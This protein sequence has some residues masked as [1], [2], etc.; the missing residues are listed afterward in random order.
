MPFFG[1]PVPGFPAVYGKRPNKHLSL[2]S[3]SNPDDD[4]YPE[5]PL[6]A[7]RFEVP[8]SLETTASYDS[9]SSGGSSPMLTPSVSLKLTEEEE[10]SNS[11]AVTKRSPNFR[12]CHH[13][14]N[15]CVFD[16]V[17]Y[18]DQV[19]CS[20]EC[21]WS[22]RIFAAIESEQGSTGMVGM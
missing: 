22:S 15:R 19:F 9:S 18:K 13:C 21:Q 14:H 17:L 11:L 3:G 2:G 5:A 7:K 20:G 8:P 12:L 4:Y 6:K 1:S 10:E 16:R